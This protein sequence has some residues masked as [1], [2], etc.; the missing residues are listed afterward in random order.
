MRL[1]SGIVLNL[2]SHRADQKFER[3]ANV[4]DSVS[5]IINELGPTMRPFLLRHSA[6]P[7]YSLAQPR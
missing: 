2:D 5:V 7:L 3:R 1:K 4:I 6:R